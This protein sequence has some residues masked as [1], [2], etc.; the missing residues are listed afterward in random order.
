[1]SDIECALKRLKH[2]KR[3]MESC[4]VGRNNAKKLCGECGKRSRVGGVA[5]KLIKL[6][7]LSSQAISSDKVILYFSVLAVLCLFSFLHALL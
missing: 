6:Q 7:C 3:L 4:T 2:S 1:M 5:V